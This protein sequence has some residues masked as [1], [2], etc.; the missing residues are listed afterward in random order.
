MSQCVIIMIFK[1]RTKALFEFLR[2]RRKSPPNVWQFGLA[3]QEVIV[4]RASLAMTGKLSAA[5]AHRMVEE[6][7]LAVVRAYMEYTGAI[8]NGQGASAPRVY[9][10]VYRRAVESNRKRLGKRRWRWPR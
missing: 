5:E 6:K 9:F 10:D 7:R 4:A 1:L 3:V 2:L 8:L